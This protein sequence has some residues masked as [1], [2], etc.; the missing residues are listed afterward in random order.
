MSDCELLAFDD[1][2]SFNGSVSSPPEVFRTGFHKES[3]GKAPEQV[4]AAFAGEI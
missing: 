3:A 4:F 2:A 1:P